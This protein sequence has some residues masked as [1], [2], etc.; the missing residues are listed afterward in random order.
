MLNNARFESC[1]TTKYFT[2]VFIN[3]TFIDKSS[4]QGKR[5]GLLFGI[6][7]GNQFKMNI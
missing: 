1:K 4:G 6:H 7:E 5:C 3:K 2:F